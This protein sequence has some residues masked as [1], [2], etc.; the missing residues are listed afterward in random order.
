MNHGDQ[1]TDPREEAGAEAGA[2]AGE[3]ELE[4]ARA[5][6]PDLGSTLTTAPVLRWLHADKS[7]ALAMTSAEERARAGTWSGVTEG[8]LRAFFVRALAAAASVG[9]E[10]PHFDAKDATTLVV[11]VRPSPRTDDAAFQTGVLR[12][13]S[14]LILG[15]DRKAESFAFTGSRTA[16]TVAS[17]PGLAQPV[18]AAFPWSAAA[19]VIGV[20]GIVATLVYGLVSQQNEVEFIKTK[21]FKKSGYNSANAKAT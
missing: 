15:A 10:L 3:L 20:A 13:I 8:E 9:G 1:E 12:A 21:P 11:N 18:A 7:L 6:Q 17:D 19:A 5:A 14:A 16:Y 4:R 2:E